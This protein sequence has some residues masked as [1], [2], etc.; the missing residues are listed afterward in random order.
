MWDQARLEKEYKTTYAGGLTDAA[1]G[2]L[3]KKVGPNQLTDKKKTPKII[4]FLKE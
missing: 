3:L 1:A 4:L 2:E